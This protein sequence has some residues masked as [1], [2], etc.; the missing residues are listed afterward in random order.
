M[1]ALFVSSLLACS[2]SAESPSGGTNDAGPAAGE[3]GFGTVTPDLVVPVGTGVVLSG[4]FTYVGSSQ[5]GLRIDILRA[6]TD[7]TPPLLKALTLTEQGPW[8]VELPKDTGPIVINGFVDVG[9]LGPGHGEP[10]VKYHG[11][12]LGSDP[13]A[14]VALVLVDG[15]AV[16]GTPLDAPTLDVGDVIAPPLPDGTAAGLPVDPNVAPPAEGPVPPTDGSVAPVV[17][18][19]A[20]ATPAPGPVPAAATTATKPK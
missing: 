1:F 8:S 20:D 5:G 2:G 11:I 7:G 10:S 19:S 12:T 14:D 3:P 4:T 15:G 9:G 18:A 17:P 6:E 13:V 16:I